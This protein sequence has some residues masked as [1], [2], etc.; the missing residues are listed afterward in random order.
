VLEFG[1]RFRP[2][3]MYRVIP[4]IELQELAMVAKMEGSSVH[5]QVNS[6]MVSQRTRN[7]DVPMFFLQDPKEDG[8]VVFKHTLGPR[9]K[10]TSAN[11]MSTLD[12]CTGTPQSCAAMTD[13]SAHRKVRNLEVR[14]GVES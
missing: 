5:D 14:E 4:S 12:H 10:Q 3:H 8:I 13:L 1:I 6:W 9:M 2:N 7:V 11:R